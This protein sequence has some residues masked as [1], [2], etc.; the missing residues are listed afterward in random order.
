MN[1]ALNFQM[2]QR[3]SAG[4]GVD[5][6]KAKIISE[7]DEN[8]LREHGYLGNGNPEILRNTLVWV[9]GLN[10]ALRAGQEHRKLRMKNC[11]LSVG[12]D[13]DRKQY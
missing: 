2:K 3:A 5:V 11:Q 10:F 12:I 7:S 8:Y 4:V 1:S 6:K 13:E 9:L